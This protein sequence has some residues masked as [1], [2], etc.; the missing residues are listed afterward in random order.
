MI[1]WQLCNLTL[2]FKINNV[3]TLNTTHSELYMVQLVINF[4]NDMQQLCD[5]TFAIKK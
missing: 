2:D 5:L 3:V 1:C 4:V